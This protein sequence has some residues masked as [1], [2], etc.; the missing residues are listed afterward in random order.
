MVGSDST[1]TGPILKTSSSRRQTPMCGRA[2]PATP[3]P[4]RVGP[5]AALTFD[6]DVVRDGKNLK[7]WLLG[8]VPGTIGKS[9]LEKAFLNS[10]KALES[11][12]REAKAEH[13]VR[14][15][16]SLVG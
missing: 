3:I 16:G 8:L 9:V 12:N 10:V 11:Q 14:G 7:G 5:T 15:G 6:V 4:L 1:T 2:P 13:A